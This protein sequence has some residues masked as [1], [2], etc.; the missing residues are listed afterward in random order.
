MMTLKIENRISFFIL[1]SLFFILLLSGCQPSQQS[2]QKA[3]P[4]V[5][6]V[7]E[8]QPGK[9]HWKFTMLNDG[10][11]SEVIRADTQH[12]ILAEGGMEIKGQDYLLRYVFGPCTWEYAEE[13]KTLKVSITVNDFHIQSPGA[14][15]NCMLIDEF[16]GPLSE[17]GTAWTPK[18]TAIMRYDPP[19]PA[20]VSDGGTLKFTKLH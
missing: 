9:S 16:E 10:T 12:M 15:L 6:A 2:S 20:R 17:D 13:S 19:A 5:A 8:S 4:G 18:W 3:E 11:L 14:E 7:W 1:Y